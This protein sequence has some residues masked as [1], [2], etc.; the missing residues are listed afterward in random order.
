MIQPFMDSAIMG[1]NPRLK[2]PAARVFPVVDDYH[3]TPVADPY[4]WLEDPGS[5]ETQRWVAAQN[6]LTS[7]VLDGPLREALVTELTHLYDYPRTSMPLK[8]GGRYFFTFNSGLQNQPSLYVQHAV[9]DR[10]RLL[11]NPNILSE[12]GT[13][14]LTAFFVADDGTRVAYGISR[15]GSDRQE[16][17]VR[18]VA[19]GSDLHDRLR[20]LKFASIAWTPASDGFYYTRFPEPGSV[21][22][23]DEQYFPKVCYHRLGTSQADDATIFERPDDREI[24]FGLDATDDDRWLVITAF[25]GASDRCEVFLLDRRDHSISTLFTSFEHAWTFVGDA[26]GRL[27]FIT[28]QHA[29]R[30]R[31]VAVDPTGDGVPV[32]VVPEGPDK[33]TAAAIAGRIL[34]VCYLTNASDGISLYQLDGEP[35]GT[36]DLP[37]YVSV[38]G[39]DGGRDG[40]LTLSVWSYTQPPAA[41]RYD[42]HRRM[43][44][45]FDPAPLLA[46]AS[47]A[48]RKPGAYATRQ[49]WFQSKDGTS[50]SMFLVQRED[51]EMDGARPVLLNGYGGFNVNMTPMYDPANR[52]LLDRG[53]VL[54][55]PQLRGGGEY[56]EAWHE[57]GMLERKQNVFDDFIAAAE[58]LIDAGITKPGRL[59]IEGGSNG[60]LL[61]ASVML[62][63]PDLFGAVVCRVPVAD[64]LRYH[65]FTIGRFWIREYGCADD[66]AQFPYL[67]RYSPYHNI[68]RSRV[69]PPVLV[70]TA[71]TDD[72]VSPGMAKKF[73]ARL[74]AEADGGPFLV[75]VDI[76]AGHGLGKPVT[77]MIDEDADIFTFLFTVLEVS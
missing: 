35:A 52:A 47:P 7:S 65:L 62:Q 40:E 34:A 19:S 26:D 16:F 45:A 6:A 10:P 48:S 25:K 74:Q 57:A 70:T 66:P 31:I 42:T 8:R 58:W 32:A 13:A 5:G 73:G 12:D 36:L 71:D 77:K 30:G 15:S 46:P 29:A 68:V 75:R 38:T 20:W 55:V 22:P 54:A 21:A 17:F 28:D 76:K 61:T 27:F 43:L 60:G 33:L 63:R 64:M 59:A 44:G 51:L 23:G 49:V 67:I 41:F 2:Y 69:Y 53:G 50:V 14:A 24:V 72:R 3:G 18:D 11:V 37:S 56:G 4:R 1:R 39:L 9:G